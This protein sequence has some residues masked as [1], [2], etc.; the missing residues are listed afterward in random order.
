MFLYEFLGNAGLSITLGF[1]GPSGRIPQ[2]DQV[3]HGCF[4][5]SDGVPDGQAVRTRRIPSIFADK[6]ER[7]FSNQSA[8]LPGSLTNPSS[9]PTWQGIFFSQTDGL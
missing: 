6:G 1:I 9:S 5:N 4:L 3:L 8:A 2:L 7:G